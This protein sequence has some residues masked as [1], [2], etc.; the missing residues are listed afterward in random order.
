MNERERKN[1][2]G[3]SKPKQ[4]KT[5]I[6]QTNERDGGLEKSGVGPELM[7][8]LRTNDSLELARVRLIRS[9]I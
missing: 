9:L 1:L 8:W 3:W 7:P 6:S 2:I 5:H 4:K